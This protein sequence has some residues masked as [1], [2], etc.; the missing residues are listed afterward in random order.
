MTSEEIAAYKR[1]YYI[2]N[3]ERIRE[4]INRYRKENPEKT[5][6]LKKRYNESPRGR[7]YRQRYNA[8]HGRKRVL[9]QY[10]FTNEDYTRLAAAQDY[11]CLICGV[12][13]WMEPG[14]SLHID[15]DH[16]TGKVRG[17]LCRHCN[18]GLGR[19]RDNVSLLESAI[20]YLRRSTV[21]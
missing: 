15:H 3:R 11:S 6:A 21:D 9:A 20:Q 18:L 8:V 14:G 2:A 16:A 10:G 19:F 17:L 4:T 13:S 1:A 5:R 7:A 12:E